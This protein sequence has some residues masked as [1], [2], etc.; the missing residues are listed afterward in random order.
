MTTD[1]GFAW[2]MYYAC[3][4][5]CKCNCSN[6][7]MWPIACDTVGGGGGGGAHLLF[8]DMSKHCMGSLSLQKCMRCRD[9]LDMRANRSVHDIFHEG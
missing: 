3:S 7:N 9:P 4:L 2:F 5:L 6:D 8:A 1:I